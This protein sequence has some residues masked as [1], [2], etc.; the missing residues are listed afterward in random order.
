[1]KNEDIRKALSPE[2]NK[3]SLPKRHALAELLND[4]ELED[5][6]AR[7]I[8]ATLMRG[9]EKREDAPAGPSRRNRR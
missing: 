5:F 6:E 3:L 4:A 2:W 9:W 8:L 1:M 7:S